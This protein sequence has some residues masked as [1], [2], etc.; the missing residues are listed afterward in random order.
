MW[1]TK[2]IIFSLFIGFIF[3]FFF[4]VLTTYEK[5]NPDKQNK[6]RGKKAKKIFFIILMKEMIL[7]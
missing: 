1:I 4:S 3:A 5:V 2:A 7:C 6:K